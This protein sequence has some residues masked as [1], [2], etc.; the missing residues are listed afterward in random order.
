MNVSRVITDY[1]RIAKK[2]PGLAIAVGFEVALLC[3]A[4][5]LV[6]KMISNEKEL[7][8]TKKEVTTTANITPEQAKKL[9]SSISWEIKNGFTSDQLTAYKDIAAK[10]KAGESYSEIK[11]EQL[12]KCQGEVV[13]IFE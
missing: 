9:E 13:K 12:E 11:K 10:L 5:G 6:G 4:G 1:T 2:H 3:C 8:V 7:A